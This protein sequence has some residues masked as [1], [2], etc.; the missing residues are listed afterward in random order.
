MQIRITR[1]V[2]GPLG[3]DWLPGELHDAPLPLA[4]ELVGMHAAEY[5]VAPQV[6]GV[7]TIETAEPLVSHRDPVRRGKR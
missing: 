6:S 7:V 1:H 3:V 4:R 2:N 5:V